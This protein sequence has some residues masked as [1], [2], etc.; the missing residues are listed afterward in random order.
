MLH[1]ITMLGDGIGQAM[2]RAPALGAATAR[3]QESALAAG[4]T[5]AH[6]RENKI[7]LNHQREPHFQTLLELTYLL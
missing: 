1:V 2:V 3:I 5:L 7:E 6:F 4:M